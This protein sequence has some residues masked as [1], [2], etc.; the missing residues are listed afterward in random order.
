V[1]GH[2]VLLPLSDTGSGMDALTKAQIFEP[3]FTTKKAGNGTGLGLCTVYGI[4]KQSGGYIF[5]D[6]APGRGTTFRLYFP[7]R[8]ADEIEPALKVPALRRVEG[9]TE[10]ILLVDDDRGVR[11]F[12]G[13]VLA[14]RGYDVLSASTPGDALQLFDGHPGGIDLLLTDVVMAG[15]TGPALADALRARYP[16][17]KVVYTSGYVTD[18]IEQAVLDPSVAFIAKP[19]TAQDLASKIRDTLDRS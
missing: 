11:E 1:H 8:T 2:Y 7:R 9:G 15:M 12:A 10:T 18:A 13:R 4:V 16:G 6:S 19:F 14:A 3:F 17:I 5:V